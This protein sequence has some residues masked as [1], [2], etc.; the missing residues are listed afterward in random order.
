MR[1]LALL[2]VATTM[3]LLGLAAPASADRRVPAAGGFTTELSLPTLTTT[4]VGARACRLTVSG[5]LTFSGT[6]EG[7]GDATTTALVFAPCEDVA[8][9]PPGAFA[10]VFRSRIAFEGTV[11]GDP[12]AADVLWVGRTE[13]GGA[14]DAVMV[15]DGDDVEG[16]LHVDAVVGQGGSYRGTLADR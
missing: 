5:V 12:V 9:S 14:I 6:L 8:T 4:P 16:L 10:D 15:V 1:R 13:A 2:L 11:A 7:T 3:V